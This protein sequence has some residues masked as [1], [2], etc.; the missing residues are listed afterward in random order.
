MHRH[1]EQLCAACISRLAGDTINFMITRRCTFRLYPSIAQAKKLS[2]WRR[3]HK[4][5]YNA[6]LYNRKTAYQRFG[7]SASYYDQQN[8]LPE[9]KK[10]WTEYQELGSQALQATL[11]RVDMAFE[12]F[13]KGLGG[14]PKFKSI[15]RYSGW[16]YPA[17]SGWKAHTTGDNG[18]LELS[19][20][21][22][23]VTHG[24]NLQD[25]W[26]FAHREHRTRSQ[27]QM[28]GKARTW[29]IPT[30]CTI[31]YRHGKWYA[32]I[33][34]QCEPVRETGTGTIGVDFGTLTAIACSD[35]AKIENPRFLANTQNKIKLA[36]IQKRRKRSPNHKKKIKGSNRCKKA[37]ARISKLQRKATNQRRDWAH[38][39]TTQIVSR[40]SMV[41]TEKLNI[42]RMTKKSKKGKRKRQ[43]SG[44]NRS[45][46]DV[47][48]G[49][50]GG[51]LEYKLAEAEGVFL[52]APTKTLKPSQ[53]CPDCWQVKP[54]TLAERI[55]Q[56]SCGCTEDRDVASAKVC[57][58]WATGLGTSLDKR[59]SQASTEK[60]ATKHCG[61]FQQAWETKRQKPPE[62]EAHGR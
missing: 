59:G 37:Q 61:G 33:T 14:Y 11:K 28:R 39:V 53:R 4:D 40:N 17:T 7:K 9:F 57:L 1:C 47:G 51:M 18:Y 48:W 35:G 29:G 50:L 55:H 3:L 12:R 45:I 38:K 32:S 19:N 43:K 22:R 42:K 27:I 44:L 49:I 16:T 10:V 6:A 58:L 26:C 62:S 54:K 15:R 41:V 2:Y 46:L 8:S 25:R 21:G 60:P 34:V 24:G 30:T 31:V 52:E 20:L 23:E 13:F 36:S 56:C 5:L